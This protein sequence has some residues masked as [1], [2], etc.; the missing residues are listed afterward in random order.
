M[1]VL[2]FGAVPV[3]AVSLELLQVF[4]SSHYPHAKPLRTFAGNVLFTEIASFGPA[5]ALPKQTR[6]LIRM[7]NIFTCGTG[8]AEEHY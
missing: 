3:G 6:A 5:L 1:A 4:V 8:P 2:L 7:R